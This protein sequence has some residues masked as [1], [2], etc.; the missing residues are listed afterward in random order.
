MVLVTDRQLNVNCY[1]P[2]SLFLM[3]LFTLKGGKGPLMVSFS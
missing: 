1:I 3:E 2:L